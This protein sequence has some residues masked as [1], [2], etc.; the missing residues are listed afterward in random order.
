MNKY[1]KI[2]GIGLGLVTL[3]VVAGATLAFNR[4]PSIAEENEVE[5]YN[6]SQPTFDLADQT[7]PGQEPFRG[8]ARFTIALAEALG[9]PVEELQAAR[10]EA[11][12]ATLVQ[13]VEEGLLPEERAEIMLARA[14][15][16]ATRE[17]VIR[18]AVDDGVITPEQAELLKNRPV[19]G[20]RGPGRGWI[21]GY[22]PFAAQGINGGP[23][24]TQG[25]TNFPMNLN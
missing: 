5:I 11:L 12:E 14:A 17:R 4:V 20:F 22:R 3:F 1:K 23:G 2:I 10:Q 21:W 19:F 8:R 6:T 15:L 7:L 18:Q 16:A 9:I 24:S 13:A 25:G